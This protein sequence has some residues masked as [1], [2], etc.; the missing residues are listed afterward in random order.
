MS[1]KL[2]KGT[3]FIW[4]FKICCFE[5]ILKIFFLPCISYELSLPITAEVLLWAENKSTD[6]SQV[7]TTA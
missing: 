2:L 4:I 1:L 7:F 5:N 3:Y 6:D